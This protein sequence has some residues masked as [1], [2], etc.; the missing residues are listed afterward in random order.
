[1]GPFTFIFTPGEQG[2]MCIFIGKLE[3]P[4]LESSDKQTET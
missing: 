3:F 1:M 4:W 2:Q